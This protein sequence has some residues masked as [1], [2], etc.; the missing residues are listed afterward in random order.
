M[1][2]T[3]YCNVFTKNCYVF[4]SFSHFSRTSY[5]TDSFFATAHA[6]CASRDSPKNSGFLTAMPTKTKILCALYNDA[7]KADLDKGYWNSKRKLGV[8]MQR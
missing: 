1:D 4:V 8:T 2:T 6:F 7:G 5:R 3:L